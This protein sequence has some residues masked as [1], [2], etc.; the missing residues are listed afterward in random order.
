MSPL[1]KILQEIL[2]LVKQA[3]KLAVER[4]ENDSCDRLALI[5]TSMIS[6]YEK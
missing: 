6:R 4:N 5:V 3:K 1:S 2:V